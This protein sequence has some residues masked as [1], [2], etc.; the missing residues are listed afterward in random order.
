V[1]RRLRRA[2]ETDPEA[3]SPLPGSLLEV[4]V[5][6]LVEVKNYNFTIFGAIP[7]KEYQKME[8]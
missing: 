3:A 7:R 1:I 6:R 2:V 4:S 8:I 5:I